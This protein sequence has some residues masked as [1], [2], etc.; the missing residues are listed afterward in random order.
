MGILLLLLLLLLFYLLTLNSISFRVQLFRIIFQEHI[1][2]MDAYLDVFKVTDIL[3][4]KK[5]VLN[6]TCLLHRHDKLFAIS[7]DIIRKI[8][9][10]KLGLVE[11]FLTI[12]LFLL[13]YHHVFLH[14]LQSVRQ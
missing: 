2:L 3:V 5:L 12:C 6:D 14:G 11:H 9:P 8:G 10:L 4:L 13:Q 7:N 1:I